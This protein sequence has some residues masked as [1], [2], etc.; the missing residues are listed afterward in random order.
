MRRILT[1]LLC[2]LLLAGCGGEGTES[3]GDS[4]ETPEAASGS[5]SLGMATQWK[6]YDPSVEEV[7]CVLS[8]EGEGA[9]LEFGSEYRLEVLED[10]TWVN[11][12]FR[13]NV[14]WDSILYTLPVGETWAFPCNLTLF[15]FEFSEGTYR[16]V[17]EIG[18]LPCEAEFTLREGASISA[19]RP[20][21]FTPLEDLPPDGELTEADLGD[22]ALFTDAGEE[23]RQAAERFQEWVALGLPCQLR[24]VQA[25]HESWPMI[26]DVIHEVGGGAGGGS[27]LWRMRTGGAVTEQRF[28]YLVTD[29]TEVYLSNGADWE[30]TEQYDSDRA[31]LVPSG[32]GGPLVDLAEELTADRLAGNITRY[33]ITSQDGVWTASLTGEE[34]TAFSVSWWRPGQGGASSGYDLQDWDGLE[35]SIDRMTWREDN[36]LYLICGTSDGGT[37]RLLFD[38]ETETL[39]PVG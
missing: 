17:K 38:P 2:L 8:S 28:S 1:A 9:P 26:I 27:F 35:T 11:V 13:E 6:E 10:G 24:T 36:T 33:R 7:W 16:V 25:Y 29:G 39:T 18:G 14:G 21:G 32:F 30:S 12:P 20:Y 37:S 23:N 4:Q 22:A 3:A 5:F 19:E 34:P 31:T 15:D